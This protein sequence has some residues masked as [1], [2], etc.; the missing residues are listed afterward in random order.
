[1]NKN[2]NLIFTG[3]FKKFTKKYCKVNNVGVLYGCRKERR[4]RK[5]N[6]KLRITLLKY[7]ECDVMVFNKSQKMLF[8]G[9][10]QSLLSML[11]GGYYANKKVNEVFEYVE[12]EKITSVDIILK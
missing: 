3:T 6:E 7:S 5:M 2:D 12:Q 11:S 1:M 8:R 10:G 4:A 9:K